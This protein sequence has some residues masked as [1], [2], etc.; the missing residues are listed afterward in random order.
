M[1]P[2]TM[3]D[4]AESTMNSSSASIRSRVRSVNGRKIANTSAFHTQSHFSSAAAGKSAV[5]VV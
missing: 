2:T 3:I 1:P 5:K 4:A